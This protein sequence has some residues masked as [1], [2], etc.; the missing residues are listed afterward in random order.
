[1][2]FQNIK[3]RNLKLLKI[4]KM[5]NIIILLSVVFI[6]LSCNKKGCTD[7]L[8]I[9]Y[10]SNATKDDSSCEYSISNKWMMSTYIIN[11]NN[12][13]DE[14]EYYKMYSYIDS[15][16]WVQSLTIND[17]TLSMSR[18]IQYDSTYT[19]DTLFTVNPTYPF[20]STTIIDTTVTIYDTLIYDTLIY[21][22]L[23]VDIVGNY[24]LGNMQSEIHFQNENIRTNS[25]LDNGNNWV[26]NDNSESFEIITLTDSVMH[27]L[28]T[29]SSNSSTNSLEISY[30]KEI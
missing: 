27:L 3:T 2:S 20:S 9:N 10:S 29:N 30:F 21:D 28:L 6:T 16:F 5:K 11:G 26:T 7:P 12:I 4:K 18:I 1:M 23:F 22:S 25:N 17:T 19:I 14:F 15:S 8:A 13:S 24:S